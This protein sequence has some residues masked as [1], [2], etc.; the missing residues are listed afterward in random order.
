M[1][2]HSLRP[3][4]RLSGAAF[5]PVKPTFGLAMVPALLLLTACG[6][7]S[8]TATPMAT[9][10]PTP[11]IAPTSTPVPDPVE[12]RVRLPQDEAAHGTPFEWW[13]FNG[14]LSD[15]QGRAYSYHFVTF[16]ITTP[17]GI[18]PRL[19]Q[20]G[21]ADHTAGRY[22]TDEMPSIVPG[23]IVPDGF[24]IRQGD[25][26]MRGDGSRYSLGFN[27]GNYALKLEAVPTKPAVL[28]QG[29]GLVDL[30]RAGESYYYT[31]G[32]LATTGVLTVDGE[33]HAVTGSGWMDRQ[34]GDFGREAPVGWDWV[35]A[36]LDDGTELMVTLLWDADDREPILTYGTYV[37]ADGLATSL[38]SD[39]IQ[40]TA[41]GT[42]TSP[43]NGT[44][45]PMGWRLE[46]TEP[47][48]SLR[49]EPVQEFAEFAGSSYLPVPYWEGAVTITGQA[50]GQNI[51][52][53]GFVEL[54]GYAPRVADNPAIPAPGQ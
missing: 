11:T 5:T 25:W 16:E 31:R 6:L 27:T 47:P 3:W 33:R 48:L 28:H 52:G 1:K 20:L 32:R 44:V 4:P 9:P 18:N 29:T 15:D 7:F 43:H 51:S 50:A 22:L 21:W 10:L 17:A 19:L 46:V 38:D 30:G 26:W 36:Q 8:A 49:L 34:W 42:W 37:A 12:R 13:Y 40:L 24:D 45:Y 53:Q 23:A 2:Y 35:S 54:V 39:D 41:T 14:H